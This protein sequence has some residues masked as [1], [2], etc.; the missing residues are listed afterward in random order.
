M[1]PSTV[2]VVPDTPFKRGGTNHRG[3][4]KR[5]GHDQRV[6]RERICQY[7]S[8]KTGSVTVKTE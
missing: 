2:G 7:S 4:R 1:S 3:L 5:E 6:P 8:S